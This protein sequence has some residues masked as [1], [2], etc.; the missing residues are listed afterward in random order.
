[1]T[2][3]DELRKHL[4]EGEVYRRNDLAKWSTSVDRHLAALVKDGAL[5]KLSQGLYFVPKSTVF[6]ETP[7]EEARLVRSFLKDNRFL[8]TS[9]NAYNNL[10]LGTTQLYNQRVVYNY[11]R[12]GE[13]KLGN[14]N[15]SFRRKYNFP[16][17]LTEEFLVV[18][19]VN[20]L[21]NLAEDKGAVLQNLSSKVQKM[22]TKKLAQAVANYGNTK[23]QKIF[24]PLLSSK[25]K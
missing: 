19:L 25:Q 21:D 10:G 11:K 2:K 23:A 12:H 17:K 3:L 24:E 9:P 16:K 13:F 20:N 22:D 7:P 5:Q 6:G 18:D 8:L 4:K 1:M 14:R 15:F